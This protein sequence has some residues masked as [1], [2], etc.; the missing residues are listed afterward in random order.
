MHLDHNIINR[1]TQTLV[2]PKHRFSL[3]DFPA[4]FLEAFCLPSL[5]SSMPAYSALY[6]AVRLL[7]VLLGVSR[8]IVIHVRLLHIVPRR[9]LII[10]VRFAHND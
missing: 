7:R 1:M 2:L 5:G 4:Y 8:V 3:V 6:S 10:P 9:L